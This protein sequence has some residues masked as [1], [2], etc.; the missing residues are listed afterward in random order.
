MATGADMAD[1]VRRNGCERI[2]TKNGLLNI[3]W[4]GPE[5]PSTFDIYKEMERNSR[6]ACEGELS[7]EEWHSKAR[8]MGFLVEKISLD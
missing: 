8:E 7:W 4:K 2:L 5:N 6:L 1:V 3:C